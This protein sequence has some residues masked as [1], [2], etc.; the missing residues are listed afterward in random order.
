MSAALIYT[1]SRQT[2]AALAM[3]RVAAA[4]RVQAERQAREAAHR[5]TWDDVAAT[6]QLCSPEQDW[7]YICRRPTDHTGEHTPE[8]IAAWREG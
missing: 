6:G 8:Q 1:S 4:G 7:C 2:S 3:A 5:R